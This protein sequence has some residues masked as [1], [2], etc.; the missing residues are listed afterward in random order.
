[1]LGG[2]KD[3][4]DLGK[5]PTVAEV[6]TNMTFT[7]VRDQDSV[8]GSTVVTIEVGTDLENWPDVYTV[9]ADTGSSTAGVTVTD[10]LDGTDTIVL[11][12]PKG[13]DAKKFAR[14]KVVVTP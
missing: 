6:G 4:N 3:T 13:M 11:T 9:G 14:L 10:N 1:M 12:V 8:D 7:F 2:D 5:L